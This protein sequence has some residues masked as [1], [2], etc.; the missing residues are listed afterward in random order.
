M[1][2]LH[3]SATAASPSPSSLSVLSDPMLRPRVTL[4]M[5][6]A[7]LFL[8]VASSP[9]DRA[10]AYDTAHACPGGTSDW[11]G[12]QLGPSAPVVVSGDASITCPTPQVTITAGS[13]KH[14]V[15]SSSN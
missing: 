1:A 11:Q 3:S 9:A 2:A 13:T 5:V 7:V 10:L 6:V 14:E 15:T 8:S 12:T 4:P